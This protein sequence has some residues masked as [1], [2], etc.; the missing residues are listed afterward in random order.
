MNRINNL[1]G[2]KNHLPQKNWTQKIN[3]MVNFI[4]YMHH[5]LGLK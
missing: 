5:D 3:F 2:T 1:K 4:S